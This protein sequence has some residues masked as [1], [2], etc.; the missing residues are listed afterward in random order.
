VSLLAGRTGGSGGSVG[1]S[2]GSGGSASS[3]GSATDLFKRRRVFQ[4]GIG[5]APSLGTAFRLP[6]LFPPRQLPEPEPTYRQRTGLF[7]PGPS[8][9]RRGINLFG[10]SPTKEPESGLAVTRRAEAIRALQTPKPLRIAVPA[11]SPSDLPAWDAPASVNNY[12]PPK[13]WR[14]L[15]ILGVALWVVS[16]M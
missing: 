3:G 4:P 2:P 8:T 14:G 12:T 10:M 9:L 16:A 1:G 6:N 15:A 7:G 11:P 5:T 13:D